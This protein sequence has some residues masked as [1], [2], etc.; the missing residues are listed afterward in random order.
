MPGLTYFPISCIGLFKVSRSFLGNHNPKISL[1]LFKIMR[2]TSI[3]SPHQ[4][5]A[6]ELHPH[7]DVECRPSTPPGNSNIASIEDIPP[8]GGY[9][10]ICTLCVF[11]INAHTWGINSVCLPP[12][13]VHN[14][15]I[16]T[17]HC[18]SRDAPFIQP[19]NA[20]LPKCTHNIYL[21]RIS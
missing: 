19:W 12:L 4:D 15:P 9:G 10:W 1:S 16:H 3:S 21:T 13:D 6:L 5:S 17:L 2:N 8:D 20:S 18:K 11:L 14:L 7:N